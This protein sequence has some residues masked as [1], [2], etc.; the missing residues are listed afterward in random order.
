M[1]VIKAVDVKKRF[2]VKERAGLFKKKQKIVQA[3]KGASLEVYE[4]EI[5]GLLGPNGAGK[6]TLIKILT[7]LLLPD[8]GRAFVMGYD[9]VK[10]PDE[11]KKRIG[12]MLMGERALYWKLTGRENLE[13]FGSLYHVPKKVLGDR[14]NEIIEFLGIQEFVDRL[15]ETYSS[16]QKVLLAFAKALIND[17]PLI[18]L[19]E[20][21]VALDPRRA[22]EVR[23]KVLELKQEGKTIFL[24]THI[25]SEAEELCD[26]IAIINDGRIV[27]IGTPSDLKRSLKGK[28]SINVEFY[29]LRPDDIVAKVGV[30]EGVYK[31]AWESTQ[32]DGKS[33][34][35]MRILCDSPKDLLHRVLDVLFNYNSKVYFIKPEE[36]T[37]EDVFMHYTGRLLG[38]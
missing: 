4:N 11:V 32:R 7:T 21:T 17:A 38:E 22:I 2:V 24:T 15:V 19:D 1:E 26:R 34:I 31:V 10:K 8:E 6:T 20:P 33:I 28:S 27:A 23:R 30:M 3:L 14:I 16:G 9:V 25:M 12:V 5:F 18:F 36:P 29:S 35:R 13:F 37:L